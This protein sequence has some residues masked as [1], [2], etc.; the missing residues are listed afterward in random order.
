MSRPLCRLA[1]LLFLLVPLSLSAQG[2]SSTAPPAPVPADSVFARAQRL[3][4]EGQADSG[5]ALVQQQLSSTTP[6][7]PAY[8]EALYWSGVLSATAAD[9]EQAYR[10]IIVEYP[11]SPRMDDALMRI[12]QLEMARGQ[13][14]EALDHL[15]RLV[16]EHP[17][18][19][20]RARANYWM[21]RVLFDE[22][23]LPRGCARLADAGQ[24]VA[25]SDVELRNQIDYYAQR[26][27]GVDTTGTAVAAAG[28]SA[29]GAPR[30][31]TPAAR[32]TAR[33]APR[34]ASPTR[35]APTPPAAGGAKGGTP[36][37]TPP[38]ATTRGTQYTVQAGAYATR[39]T[40]DAKRAALAAAGFD[41]RV[42]GA[43]K[44]YRVRVGRYPSRAAALDVARQLVRRKL[45][46]DAFVT[47][48]EGAAR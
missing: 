22:G 1:F 8:A 6:G 20:A 35:P 13:H 25:S 4:A 32:D 33:V 3:V 18:S 28:D 10:R 16:R 47:E 29:T 30:T 36:P 14:Q 7:T 23:D 45:A 31:A 21:A 24:R 46:P 44:L 5:R 39:T 17:D 9:A 11:L 26:C 37:S 27:L 38:A 15:A 19:P 2:A 41:A 43:G 42:I 48:A 34:P 40:A 12:A